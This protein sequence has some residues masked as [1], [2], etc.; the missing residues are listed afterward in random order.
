MIL[1]PGRGKVCYAVVDYWEQL[2][3]VQVR[4]TGRVGLKYLAEATEPEMEGEYYSNL[5]RNDLF[6][7]EKHARRACIIRRAKLQAQRGW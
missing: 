2:Y 3:V 6:R 5:I 7:R 1:M 4:I